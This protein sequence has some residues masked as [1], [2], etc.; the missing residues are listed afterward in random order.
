M[1]QYLFEVL[2]CTIVATVVTLL[3]YV[4]GLDRSWQDAANT[5]GVCFLVSFAIGVYNRLKKGEKVKK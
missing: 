4:I 1:K 2:L 3:F 5:F